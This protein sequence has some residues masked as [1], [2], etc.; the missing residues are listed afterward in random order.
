MNEALQDDYS[1]AADFSQFEGQ[2]ENI[3]P[4]RQGRSAAKLAEIF[5]QD[6]ASRQCLLDDQQ[7]AFE[8]EVGRINVADDEDPLDVYHRYVRWTLENFPQG[9]NQASQLRPL[10]ERATRCFQDDDRYLNDPRYL[11]LWLLYVEQVRDGG[12]EEL[13]RFLAAKGIGQDLAMY[14]EEQARLLERLGKYEA[15]DQAYQLGIHRRAQPAS[16]LRQRHGEFQRR[17][18]YRA[19]HSDEEKDEVDALTAPTRGAGRSSRGGPLTRKPL[20]GGPRPGGVPLVSRPTAEVP[21]SNLSIFTDTAGAPEEEPSGGRLGRNGSEEGPWADFGTQLSRRKENIRDATSW[22]GAKLPQS[23]RVRPGLAE[24]GKIDIFMDAETPVV[25]ADSYDA[26]PAMGHGASLPQ[27][28]ETRLTTA[29]EAAPIVGGTVD[30]VVPYGWIG[31]NP[32]GHG[33]RLSPPDDNLPVT[34]DNPAH[35]PE[36]FVLH[37][38]WCRQH[39]TDLSLEELRAMTRRQAF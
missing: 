38:K 32:T 4:R 37:L 10:V 16:R 2:K 22:A 6:D 23:G 39:N 19:D 1:A 14:Y 3:Q 26:P 11:R 13:F 35:R 28:K 20:A 18:A 36:Y 34:P 24:G 8:A 30:P 5:G 9:H 25:A 21:R 7:R 15:A 12:Q 27:D 29:I 33:L 17:M 31:Y